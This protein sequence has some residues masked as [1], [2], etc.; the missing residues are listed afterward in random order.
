M[1]P[2]RNSS[3]LEVSS[4]LSDSSIVCPPPSVDVAREYSN[5]DQISPL[6]LVD[7][8]SDDLLDQSG[9]MPSMD[10]AKEYSYIDQISPI[11]LVDV[12]SD[13]GIIQQ[14]PLNSPEP[15]VSSLSPS[16]RDIPRI[17]VTPPEEDQPDLDAPN[18]LGNV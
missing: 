1:T 18:D 17:V 7:L 3:L 13:D 4:V 5:I 2:D 11:S 10:I 8:P 9:P 16:S 6:I 15:S 12:S 14:W